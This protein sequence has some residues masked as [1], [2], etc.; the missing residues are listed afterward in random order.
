MRGRNI[1]EVNRDFLVAE[2][3]SEEATLAPSLFE[4]LR[5]YRMA[6]DE[7]VQ[8][9]L[10]GQAPQPSTLNPRLGPAADRALLRGVARDPAAR[11]QTGVQMVAALRQALLEGTGRAAERP[12][13]RRRWWPWALGAAA[14]VLL[15]ALVGYLVW[16]ASQ[17]PA[18]SMTVSRSCAPAPMRLRMPTTQRSSRAPAATWHPSLMRQRDTCDACT[19]DAGR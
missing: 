14:L 2:A 13:A 3:R 6:P 17:P 11:W 9:H 18:P 7:V 5:A 16:R 1:H 15:A 12:A 8:A 19:R 10:R 4:R